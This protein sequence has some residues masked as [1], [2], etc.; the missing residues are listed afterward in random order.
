MP[1]GCYIRTKPNKRKSPYHLKL[2]KAYWSMMGRCYCP[3]DIGYNLYGGRGVVVCEEWKGKINV[4]CKWAIDNGWEIG[5]QL[6]KDKK[7][8]GLLYSPDTCSFLT[9]T[10]NMLYRR[11]TRRFIY[12]GEELTIRQISEK[13][14][15]SQRKLN[16]IYYKC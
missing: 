10:A 7:G 4:F 12:N 2:R 8:D 1:V 5:L 3:K 11:N 9:Q 13:Y 15:I 16:Y 6:D 14:G